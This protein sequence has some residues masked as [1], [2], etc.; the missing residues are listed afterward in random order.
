MPSG[1]TRLRRRTASAQAYSLNSSAGPG[2]E[3][4]AHSTVPT[5]FG[6]APTPADGA[7]RG[8][9]DD[10]LCG[11]RAPAIASVA[12]AHALC[13]GVLRFDLVT[14]SRCQQSRLTFY[15]PTL[16]VCTDVEQP[17]C[18]SSPSPL[19]ASALI[20][21]VDAVTVVGVF[22]LLVTLELM[23]FCFPALNDPA[24]RCP[25]SLEVAFDL[26]VRV[27][28]AVPLRCGLP[29]SSTRSAHGDSPRSAAISGRSASLGA[30][31]DGTLMAS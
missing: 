20:T 1:N 2:R 24:H 30:S 23:P 15:K 3:D 8:D 4:H 27:G 31:R 7:R 16:I 18:P 25:G 5:G 29:R 28:V 10:S 11:D 9:R 26:P 19:T 17:A 14:W 21:N 12:P 13:L 6:R 22:V